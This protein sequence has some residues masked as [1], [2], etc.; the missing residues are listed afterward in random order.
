L[1]KILSLG[2]YNAHSQLLVKQ[3]E[4]EDGEYLNTAT[5]STK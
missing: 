2:K 1:Y 3:R 5:P 4:E